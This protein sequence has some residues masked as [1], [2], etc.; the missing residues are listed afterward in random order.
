MKSMHSLVRLTLD[1]GVFPT[2]LCKDYEV[3]AE[4][5]YESNQVDMV[6][7]VMVLSHSMC[8]ALLCKVL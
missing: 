1:L 3:L 4:L 6:I 5:F 8:S 2:Q 7:Q